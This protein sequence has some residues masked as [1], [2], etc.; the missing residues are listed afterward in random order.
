MADDEGVVGSAAPGLRPML[1]AAERH[2]TSEMA[3]WRWHAAGE[4]GLDLCGMR[5]ALAETLMERRGRSCRTREPRSSR[6]Q[7]GAGRG[8][9]RWSGAP[10]RGP[11]VRAQQG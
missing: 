4:P 8:V 9:M 5:E 1:E 3:T 10:S 6:S 7:V 11:S 2:L